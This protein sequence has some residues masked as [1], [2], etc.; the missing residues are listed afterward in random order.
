MGPRRLV[1]VGGL[2]AGLVLVVVLAV[3]TMSGGGAK[4]QAGQQAALRTAQRASASPSPSSLGVLG[5]GTTDSEPGALTYFQGKDSG[6]AGHVKDVRW[7]GQFLRV[8][9]DYPES[10]DNSRAALQLC[11]WTWDYLASLGAPGPVFIQGTSKDNGAVVLAKKL[12]DKD[13]CRVGPTI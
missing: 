3:A 11:Q 8:Y 6:V 10:A 13:S 12:D 1:A 9:T 7:S 2:F 4:T 5:K